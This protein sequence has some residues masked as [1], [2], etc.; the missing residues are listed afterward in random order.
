M[1]K[2]I[3]LRKSLSTETKDLLKNILKTDDKK[4]YTID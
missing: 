2:N 1:T 4:R 3:L